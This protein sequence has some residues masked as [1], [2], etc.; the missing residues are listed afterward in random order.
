[1]LLMAIIPS[2]TAAFSTNPPRALYTG[3]CR[4]W[5]AHTIKYKGREKR[6]AWMVSKEES[7]IGAPPR[8][9]RIIEMDPLI[10]SVLLESQNDDP[11]QSINNIHVTSVMEASM[12]LGVW[13]RVLLKGRLPILEDFASQ[14][15]WPVDPLFTA[16]SNAM[17]QLQLPRFILRHPDALSTVLSSLL[18]LTMGFQ[19]K[20]QILNSD[21]NDDIENEE[22]ELLEDYYEEDFFLGLLNQLPEEEEDVV[23]D[24]VVAQEIASS[25]MDQ[26]GGVVMGVHTLDQLFGADHGLLNVQQEKQN[27]DSDA[28]TTFGL[29][30]GVWQHSGWRQ[31]PDLQNRLANMVELRDMMKQLGRRPSAEGTDGMRRFAP[32]KLHPDGAP[33]AHF[34][35]MTRTSVIGLTFSGSL[36]EMLPSEAVLL[37]S[38]SPLLRRL[39]L[40]K[41]VE[42]K[43]LSYEMAGYSDV[44]SVPRA[45]PRYR[46]RM[47]SGPG[48]PLVVC[49]DTSWSMS[50]TREMLSKAVVLACVTAAHKQKRN[51]Q[52]V[53]FSNERGVMD[54]GEIGVDAS[55]IQRLLDFLT[56]SF[57]GGTDVTGALKYAMTT[58][59]SDT[60]AAADL[61]L[62]TDGEIPD[63][64]V[65][66]AIMEDLERL[67]LRTGM[68]IHGLLVGNHE[69]KALNKICTQTHDFLIN[70]DTLPTSTSRDSDILGKLRLGRYEA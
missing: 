11:H 51:C 40:A 9:D 53:A 61:L 5:T 20:T 49:L 43:L 42:S 10:V 18:F 8:R 45:R 50:G 33:G 69:S 1:L 39:F 24:D 36:S 66:E 21:G 19:E 54:A 56:N 59:D 34:D 28:S 16:I 41:K 7:V 68:E 30:D 23:D 67:K 2:R 52:V 6:K 60:M 29:Q 25:F 44:P 3:T 32:Q 63:P 58:L 22:D 4:K 64:P 17:A 37:R 35:P 65:S 48:G 38:K 55:G 57:G 46:P 14:K 47:P 62:V 15:S 27:G 70:Y 26:F 31:L 12:G 13:R